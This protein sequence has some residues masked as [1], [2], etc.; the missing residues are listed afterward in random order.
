[1]KYNKPNPYE[2]IDYKIHYFI[3]GILDMYQYYNRSNI[4][5]MVREFIAQLGDIR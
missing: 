5:Y 3:K 2:D 4:W 1:M